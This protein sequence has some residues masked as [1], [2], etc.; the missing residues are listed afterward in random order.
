MVVS[1]D[2]SV[3][4]GQMMDNKA[5]SVE[6]LTGGIEFLFKKNKVDYI[7]GFGAV[8]DDSHVGVTATDGTKQVIEGAHIMI[9]TGCKSRELPPLP[10]NGKSVISSKEATKTTNGVAG[11]LR[12]SI[13]DFLRDARDNDEVRDEAGGSLK[14]PRRFREG[15]IS[16]VRS[17][18]RAAMADDAR[19]HPRSAHVG[20][21]AML[22][23]HQANH[24]NGNDNVYNP[25]QCF[26]NS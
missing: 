15:L 9:A 13:V 10:F 4:L 22:N 1:G 12:L 20:A 7:R 25:N 26:H 14:Y 6:S 3:D 23:Q 19:Q 5:K 21:F 2:V 8:L 11:S 17:G 18:S 16:L 24:R